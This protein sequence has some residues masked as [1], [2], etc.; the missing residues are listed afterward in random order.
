MTIMNLTFISLFLTIALIVAL[1]S[2]AFVVNLN[3]KLTRAKNNEGKFNGDIESNIAMLVTK[4]LTHNLNGLFEI[5]EFNQPMDSTTNHKVI[6]SE[7]ESEF[8]NIIR[9]KIDPLFLQRVTSLIYREIT[10]TDNIIEAIS[11]ELCI[12]S[13]QLNRKVKLMTGMTTSH[14]IL[15]TRLKK[16]KKQLTLTQKPIGE[17]AM[18]CGFNDFAYFS[19][20]FKKEFDM[21]PSAFQRIPHSVNLTREQA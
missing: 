19:R 20:S 10:N 4:Q 5:N 14:L 16:A 17:I 8:D 11:S 15:E 3:K 9:S 18:E 1:I 13:S 21:T 6:K 7:V 2:F 12:S